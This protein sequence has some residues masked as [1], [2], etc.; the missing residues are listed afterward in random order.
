MR[1]KQLASAQKKNKPPNINNR[2]LSISVKD[3]EKSADG[4]AYIF[5]RWF[6]LAQICRF[7]EVMG[8]H[9]GDKQANQS[10]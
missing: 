3:F 9:E 4:S 5:L 7:T 1:I 10:S 8:P 2:N 6:K